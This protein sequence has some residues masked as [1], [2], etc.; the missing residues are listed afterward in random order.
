MDLCG[1]HG[2]GSV[3]GEKFR[4]PVAPDYTGVVPLQESFGS[5]N[6]SKEQGARGK[7]QG[8]RLDLSSLA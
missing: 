3:L 4:Q 2:F 6:P 1:F 5:L 7:E 8:A